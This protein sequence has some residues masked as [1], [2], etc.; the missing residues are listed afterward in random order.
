MFYHSNIILR[1]ERGSRSLHIHVR[2][3]HTVSVHVSFLSVYKLLPEIHYLLSPEILDSELIVF[4]F[5][6]FQNASSDTP[7]KFCLKRKFAKVEVNVLVTLKLR[8]LY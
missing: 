2:F 3:L 7:T 8:N 6:S 1:S 4:I 5:Y